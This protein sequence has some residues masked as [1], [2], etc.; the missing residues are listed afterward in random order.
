MARVTS[1]RGPKRTR[2]FK[3]KRWPKKRRGSKRPSA[4]PSATLVKTVGVP[5][6]MFVKM[7]YSDLTLLSP[8]AYASSK[9]YNINNVWDPETGAINTSAYTLPQFSELYAQFRVRSVD[10][11][12]EVWNTGTLPAIGYVNFA[13]FGEGLEPTTSVTTWSTN[14]TRQFTLRPNPIGFTRIKGSMP[15]ARLFGITDA[16]YYADDQYAGTTAG[17]NP[18]SMAVMTIGARSADSSQNVNVQIKVRLVYHVELFDKRENL[19]MPA[20]NDAGE[21]Q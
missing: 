3:A 7:P 11:I 10:Y 18:A 4:R 9:T 15:V 19:I 12:V 6:R 14:Y 2:S 20:R 8:G 13:P 16:K 5:D 1:K 17:S 21:E